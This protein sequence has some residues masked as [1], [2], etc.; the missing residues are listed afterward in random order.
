[1]RAVVMQHEEHEGPGLLGPAL[2]AAGFTLVKR[3][4]GVKRED[5]DAELV[6]VLGGPMGV[7]EADRHPFLG[8]E[9]ALLTE[10]LAL[11]RPV[12]GVCLGA[13]LLAAA[14]GSEVF[15]GKNGLEVGVS[16]VRWTKEGLADPVIGGVRPKSVVAHWHQDTFKPVA[17]ATLLASTDRY[18]Q[19]AFRL[20]DSYGFQFHL[21][22]T[23]DEL[24]RWF[25]DGAEE[26]VE[27]YEKNLD[28][29]RSQLP[30]LRSAEQENRELLERLA[31]HFARV[32]RASR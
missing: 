17:G 26:L 6:V 20:G 23:A 10:R 3:F 11:E 8:E 18:T 13:Q 32:A 19:Q 7:Y 2:E 4:R 22:L 9:L 21:E 12:L 16:P 24:E 14:A 27:L 30:K 28:E 5:V 15:V 1:M 31:H 29:L 25:T